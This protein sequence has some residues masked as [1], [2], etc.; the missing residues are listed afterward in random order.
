MGTCRRP[1]LIQ[2]LVFNMALEGKMWLI[3]YLLFFFNFMFWLS[4]LVLMF[5]SVLIY[6][7]YGGVFMF[8]DNKVANLP[9]LLLIL[10]IAVFIIGFL[11]CRGADKE[12]RCLLISFTS[13]MA[14]VILIGVT[15]TILGVVYKSSVNT[16]AD[17]A[18]DRAVNNYNTT[19]GSRKMMDWIQ[20]KLKCCGRNGPGDYKNTTMT[21]KSEPGQGVASCHE[22]AKCSGE[23]Y[24]RGCKNAFIAFIRKNLL[25]VTIVAAG[26][27]LIQVIGI[28]LSC[29][30][31]RALRLSSYQEL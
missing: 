12:N 22:A 18:L 19:V 14:V 9:V 2:Q 17:K 6:V 4:G 31:I 28:A 26:V 5:T 20:G 15:V 8:T 16:M 24:L 27:M 7:K 13:I 21:C 11:G 3:K 10:G 30:L 29:S 1:S 25:I 23:L